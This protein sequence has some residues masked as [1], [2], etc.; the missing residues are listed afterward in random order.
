MTIHLVGTGGFAT[1]Q[2]AVDAA[3]NGDTIVVEAGTYVEQ[4]TI[5]GNLGRDRARKIW[6]RAS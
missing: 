6:I 1:I 2:E 4:V 5:E 3:S